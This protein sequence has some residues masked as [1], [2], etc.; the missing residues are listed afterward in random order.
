MYDRVT[1][2]LTLF[3]L[4]TNRNDPNFDPDRRLQGHSRFPQVNQYL[5]EL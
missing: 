5:D 1:Q 4:L 3:Y 2:F